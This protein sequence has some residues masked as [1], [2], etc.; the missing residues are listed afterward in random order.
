MRRF[1]YWFSVVTITITMVPST[2]YAG[3]SDPRPPAPY[4]PSVV[5]VPQ[6]LS[7]DVTA[8]LPAS[9]TGSQ[10]VRFFRYEGSTIVDLGEVMLLPAD[11]RQTTLRDAG[12][13]EVGVEYGYRVSY[14]D[15]NDGFESYYSNP[16]APIVLEAVVAPSPVA[17]QVEAEL[18]VTLT[19]TLGSVPTELTWINFYRDGAYVGRAPVANSGLAT[20]V[21]SGDVWAGTQYSYH[22]TMTVDSEGIESAPSAP[23]DLTVQGAWVYCGDEFGVKLLTPSPGCHTIYRDGFRFG[24]SSGNQQ[25]WIDTNILAGVSYSYALQAIACGVPAQTGPGIPIGD[26]VVPVDCGPSDPKFF[27]GGSAR[28]YS[29]DGDFRVAAIPVYFKDGPH[30]STDAQ[31]IYDHLFADEFGIGAYVAEGS[32]S[33]LT[34]TGPVFDWVA[35]PGAPGDDYAQARGRA[36]SFVR[37]Q[38]GLDY[39]HTD[40]DN[41][42]ILMFGM[43]PGP[44]RGEPGSGNQPGS[45]LVSLNSF[46]PND[47]DN[48]LTRSRTMIIAHESVAHGNGLGDGIAL[49]M[50]CP[51][52]QVPLAADRTEPPGCF[53]GSSRDPMADINHFRDFQAKH[54]LQLGW[55]SYNEIAVAAADAGDISWHWV[56]ASLAGNR[57]PI[58]LLYVPLDDGFFLVEFRSSTGFDGLGSCVSCDP[59]ANQS[60]PA[61]ESGIQLRYSPSAYG[62]KTYLVNDEYGR[63]VFEVDD[64]YVDSVR[65]FDNFRPQ[66]G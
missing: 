34:V 42:L 10:N 64:T 48:A 8:T 20:L 17:T 6:T 52:G 9:A 19:V 57:H 14:Y 66:S 54:K 18:A 13:L 62:G 4:P 65:K 5:Q 50:W 55:L 22:A 24:S 45:S 46:D 29:F 60:S 30:P 15:P 31:D 36:I 21:D 38:A 39:V 28:N 12:G 53:I 32:R 37:Y 2:G 25:T 58:K 26:A 44:G 11:A 35:V 33:D 49:S 3:G 56:G 16:L 7:V 40:Y 47:P 43:P 59:P 51:G 61:L 63:P 23:I 1:I 27:A 41:E